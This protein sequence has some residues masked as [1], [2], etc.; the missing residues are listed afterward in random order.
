MYGSL[1]CDLYQNSVQEFGQP[2]I[3]ALFEPYNESRPML[4]N[5]VYGVPH[6]RHAVF[7]S[8]PILIKL[9]RRYGLILMG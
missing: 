4:W 8:V 3:S 7:R 9:H 1:E 2:S 6:S 5:A